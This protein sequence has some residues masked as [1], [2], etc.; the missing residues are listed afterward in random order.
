MP[1]TI[2]TDD[3]DDMDD[4]G[5]KIIR[6]KVECED[7]GENMEFKGHDSKGVRFG[8]TNDHEHAGVFL[9]VE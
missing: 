7:C 5:N 4:Y 2:E 3:Y 1:H 9:R 8:C 6:V